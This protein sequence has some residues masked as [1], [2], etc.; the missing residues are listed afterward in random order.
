MIV[1]IVNPAAG[2]GRGTKVWREIECVLQ[3]HDVKYQVLFTTDVGHAR[4]LTKRLLQETTSGV[5]PEVVVAVGGDGTVNEVVNG[6][7]QA[8]ESMN[9]TYPD[10]SGN[11][12]RTPYSCKFGYIPAGSGNDYARGHGIPQN[13][14]EAL[15][16]LLSESTSSFIDVLQIGNRVAANSIGCGLDGQIAKTTNQAAYKN[17]LNRLHLGKLSYVLSLIRVISTY[18]PSA[19]TLTVDG[20]EFNLSKVWFICAANIPYYGGGMK[21]CPNAMP[22]DGIAEI[23]V[24][25]GISRW[26]L[27]L[28][29]P[30]VYSGKHVK[31]PAASFYSGNSIE[32]VSTTPL[33][34]HTDGEVLSED[35]PIK[36]QVLP[37][38]LH[39]IRK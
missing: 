28:V 33:V 30:L 27:L 7:F 14:L 4:E 3:Q 25:S 22:H 31:H 16:L 10:Q 1:F 19:A 24:V 39:I 11:N 17:L 12:K 38:R 35:V 8:G 23:C 26:E 13:P 21:I 9:S 37:G 15:K 34:V 20:M 6:F 2:N 32:I 5:Y 29:F 36:I 18:R